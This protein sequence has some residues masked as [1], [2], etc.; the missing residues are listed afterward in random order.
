MSVEDPD[1]ADG[2]PGQD[3]DDL[4]GGA[5]AAARA[6]FAEVRRISEEAFDRPEADRAAYVAAACGGDAAL[7]REVHA[8]LDHDAGLDVAGV[9]EREVAAAVEGPGDLV[10]VQIGGFRVVR[11]IGAGGMGAVWEAEQD[12]PRRRVALKTLGAGLLDPDAVARFR[13]ESEVLARLRHPNI[14]TIHE[15][16]THLVPS[17]AGAVAVPYFAMEYVRDARTLTAWASERGLDL[18]ARLELFETVCAAVHHGHLNGVVHRDLKPANLL[19]GADGVPKVIDFGVARA[20]DL[21]G[22]LHT[23]TGELVGTLQYMS[24]E[25]VEG[26][27]DRIDARADVYALGAVLFELLCGAPPHDLADRS[28]SEVIRVVADQPARGLRSIDPTLPAELD[29][30][31]A[32]A[33]R[34]EREL[35]YASAEAL[36]QDVRRF[37][38]HEPVSAGPTSAGYHLR[39]WV[40]R[41]R[42]AVSFAAAL[43]VTLVAG[44]VALA[45]T[46]GR[47][48][49]ARERAESSRRFLSE[50]LG[51]STPERHGVDVRV[52]DMLDDAAARLVDAP[53]ADALVA[54]DVHFALGDAYRSL[55]RYVESERHLRRAFELRSE[56]LDRDDP[57]L[58]HAMV[59]LAKVLPMNREL[60]EAE[61][62]FRRSIAALT[63]R[64]GESSFEVLDASGTLTHT[65]AMMGRGDE[66]LALARRMVDLHPPDLR[67]PDLA[68]LRAQEM[69]SHRLDDQGDAA[70]ARRALEA[71]VALRAARAGV[72]EDVLP[73]AAFDLDLRHESAFADTP[74]A[75]VDALLAILA[76][77]Q[78][79]SE[80]AARTHRDLA[81]ALKEASNFGIYYLEWGDLEKARELFAAVLAP[82]ERLQ[83]PD[84]DLVGNA[85]L[86]L[87]QAL[88][89]AG[90]PAAAADEMR[91][92]YASRQRLL[93]RESWQTFSARWYLIEALDAVGPSEEL[94]AELACA[95]EDVAFVF[96]GAPIREGDLRS[97]CGVAL[98]ALGRDDEAEREWLRAYE[99]NQAAGR[100]D[101][102]AIW[103]V[104]ELVRLYRAQ[105]RAD[106]LA[107]WEARIPEGV[108]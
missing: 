28:L 101:H 26:R 100:D 42:V 102:N 78:Q 66:A 98:R 37:R 46:L 68:M 103:P 45:V 30:I 56:A 107:T 20:S 86:G 4:V 19:V 17:G 29:W 39:K 1:A 33:L 74:D 67:R 47:E 57:E 44:L 79:A 58:V 95:V 72:A 49:V 36:R 34:P 90:Q 2:G 51:A 3:D 18:P 104:M 97:R 69:L 96:P 16:G 35:R 43:L 32:R 5:A 61:V 73:A 13:F 84:G 77:L 48:R 93:G 83:G 23:R 54:S 6:R 53:P 7:R 76:A 88:L 99:V 59:E 94:A 71:M 31:T 22:A 82:A 108:R 38:S 12:E 41:H 91:R 10:G 55:G 11:R 63:A 9:V 40:R 8:I 87:G 14:A 64:L 25:Q 60:A 75:A 27:S 81:D 92:V 15:A 65:L 106:D 80:G 105:G 62:L 89:R 52:V 85:R 21:E 24:P 50:M 70:G